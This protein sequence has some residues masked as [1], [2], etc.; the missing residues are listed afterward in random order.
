MMLASAIQA[1]FAGRPEQIVD[2]VKEGPKAIVASALTVT[3]MDVLIR[4]AD[5]IAEV[6]WQAGRGDAQQVLDGLAAHADQAGGLGG[7]FLGPLACCSGWSG[8]W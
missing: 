6:V 1:G 4:G 3:V 8:C 2:A 7:T 5:E